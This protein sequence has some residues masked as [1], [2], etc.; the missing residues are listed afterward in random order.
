MKNDLL[1]CFTN[2]KTRGS[3][4][5]TAEN[6]IENKLTFTAMMTTA[7]KDSSKSI[8]ECQKPS[9]KIE[10]TLTLFSNSEKRII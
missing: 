4:D 1:V 8:K 5:V 2:N 6:K 9:K 3:L 7:P 10:E